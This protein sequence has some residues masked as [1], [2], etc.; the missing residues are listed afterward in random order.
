ML[1]T[2]FRVEKKGERGGG[3]EIKNKKNEKHHVNDSS[4]LVRVTNQLFV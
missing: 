4:E 2:C 3:I 1:I